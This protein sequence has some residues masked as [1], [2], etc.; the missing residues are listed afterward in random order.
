MRAKEQRKDP[1]LSMIIDK[2]LTADAVGKQLAQRQSDERS[3]STSNQVSV[4]S[5]EDT[6]MIDLTMDDKEKADG[7][8]HTAPDN[9]HTKLSSNVTACL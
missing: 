4:N 3:P 5:K 2:L 8:A 9:K 6:E 1:F 7:D